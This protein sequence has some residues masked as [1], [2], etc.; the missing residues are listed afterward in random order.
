MKEQENTVSSEKTLEST[1]QKSPYEKPRLGTVTLFADQVM[2]NCKSPSTPS[3]C[4][5]PVNS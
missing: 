5:F 1:R 4:N 3:V 2:G